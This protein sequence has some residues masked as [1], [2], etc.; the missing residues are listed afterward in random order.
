MGKEAGGLGYDLVTH[1]SRFIN[2]SDKSETNHPCSS[3]YTRG[4]YILYI[5]IYLINKVKLSYTF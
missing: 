4:V 2:V 5:Y 1:P 3:G